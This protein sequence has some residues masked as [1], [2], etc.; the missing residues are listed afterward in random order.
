MMLT[1]AIVVISAAESAW[2][3]F[4]VE[5]EQ[6]LEV[7]VRAAHR[8]DRRHAAE[9]EQVEG[10][11]AQDLR[12]RRPRARRCARRSRIAFAQEQHQRHRDD[13][14]D[15][16]QH[17]EGAPPAQLL[18]EE[19]RQLRDEREPDPDPDVRDPHGVAAGLAEVA[20]E[21]HLIGQWPGEHVPDRVQQI[22]GEEHDQRGRAAEPGQRAA[23]DEDPHDHGAPRA[24]AIDEP[25]REEPEQR[26]DGELSHHVPH[27]DLAAGPAQILDEE[28]V[29]ERQAVEDQPDDREQRQ[30]RRRHE[31]GRLG[32]THRGRRAGGRGR[33]KTGAGRGRHVQ[34]NITR[35]HP[36]GPDSRPAPG[37]TRDRTRDRTREQR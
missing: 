28:V 24:H 22:E 36:E 37:A 3:A 8:P 18:G 31:P 4:Q 21:Q 15:R 34:S 26:P 6:Q 12:Q 7:L 23:G 32:P 10:P 20:R 9:R 11:L 17:L 25:A 33:L 27:G 13:D 35:A 19:A 5:R 1:N 16:P 14:H 30:E 29:E 2:L